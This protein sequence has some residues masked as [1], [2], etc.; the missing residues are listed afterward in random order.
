MSNPV[1]SDQDM[2]AAI[3]Q[4]GAPRE[5]ALQA[6]Y[7]QK[8]LRETIFQHVRSTGGSQHDAQDVL[9]ES[10]ILLDRNIRAGKFAGKSALATYFVAIAKW[11]WL[12]MRRK[13]GRYT[14]LENAEWGGEG[15]S[16]EHAVL[17]EEQRT[18]LE[19][20]LAQLGQRCRELLTLYKLDYSM[21]EIAQEMQYENADVAKKEA[22]RCRQGL[23]LILEKN[24]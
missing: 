20:A 17:Q 11:Q 18:L 6:L 3:R 2:V 21:Q 15:E 23:R 4:G 13:Q 24:R 10:L 14:A 22:Y 9:Q 12:A 7:L 19:N 8:G 16:P 1:S 5:S